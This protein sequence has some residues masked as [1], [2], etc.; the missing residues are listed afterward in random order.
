[1]IDRVGLLDEGFGVGTFEDDDYCVRARLAGF[2]A[3]IA[4]DVFVHH[5][6]GVSFAGIGVDYGELMRRNEE[7]FRS[8]WERLEG[9]PPEALRPIP[10][11]Q[12]PEAGMTDRADS[13]ERHQ[14]LQPAD[15]E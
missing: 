8:K 11:A 6:G 5:A 9:P 3:V 14:Q 12:P 15:A 7:R 10:P 13:G 1:V 4:R 2:R